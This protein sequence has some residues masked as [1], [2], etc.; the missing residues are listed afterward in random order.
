[1]RVGWCPRVGMFA[2]APQ[3]IPSWKWRSRPA[4]GNR[5]SGNLEVSG[6]AYIAS[7]MPLPWILV[8]HATR[9]LSW[10]ANSE[11]HR[12]S[13]FKWGILVWFSVVILSNFGP[14]F[15]R[16]SIQNWEVHMWN[17]AIIYTSF[18]TV[19]LVS[20]SPSTM[21]NVTKEFESLILS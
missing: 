2:F 10:K 18:W 14:E 17:G 12:M 9:T 11:C 7:T 21:I 20:E 4:S 8:P 3:W 19:N 15:S 16:L 1:M 13:H 6:E 5:Q